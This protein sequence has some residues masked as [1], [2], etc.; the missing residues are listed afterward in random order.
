MTIDELRISK[1]RIYLIEEVIDKIIN[2]KKYQVNA[3]MLSNDINNYSLD[4]VPTAPEIEKWII[5]VQKCKDIYSLRSRMAY[6]Q[7]TITNLKSM[8]FFE[9]FENIIKSNNENGILPDIENIES[10][11]CLNPGTMI[12]NSDGKTAEFEIQIQITY[13]KNKIQHS[14]SL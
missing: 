7:E 12:S 13:R 3:N 1:L 2:D 5:G 9:Q 4:K 11:E 10:I 14:L 8:G 6:G